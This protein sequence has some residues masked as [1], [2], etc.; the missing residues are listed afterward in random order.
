MLING[1]EYIFLDFDGVI[2]DSI[3][4]KSNA[5]FK[6]FEK[7]G[8]DIASKVRNHH[9]DNGGLSRL[10]KLTIY[11]R[12]AGKEPT[13]KL[14]CDYCIKFSKLVK[15]EVIE[16]KWVPGVL[17]F[18]IKNNKKYSYF[19]VTAAPQ[20]EI[21]EI[22]IKLNIM[23]YFVDVIGAPTKKIE[24]IKK[25]LKQYSIS[26]NNSIMIGDSDLDFYAANENCVP[27]ILRRTK[28][29][30][31]LQKELDCPKIYNFM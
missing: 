11:L 25:I 27:F 13:E 4:V 5:F 22:M 2:K 29:N 12:W 20:D 30:K 23:S 7:F 1:C 31:S 3:G 19:L 21:E 6:L 10:E 17:D 18:I 16:S 14:I 28:Y 9:E 24:A 8:H 26:P 15:Q